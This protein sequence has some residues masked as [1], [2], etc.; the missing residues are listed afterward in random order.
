MTMFLLQT[1]FLVL[2]FFL[3][4]YFVA[5]FTKQQFY[6]LVV[7]RTEAGGRRDAI[8]THS[9]SRDSADNGSEQ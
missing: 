2:L 9:R 5:R 6:S 1:A 7:L 4:G 3:G 8:G